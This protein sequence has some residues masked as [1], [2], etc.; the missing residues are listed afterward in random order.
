MSKNVSGNRSN[1][2]AMGI[3]S[4][5]DIMAQARLAFADRD[6]S[7]SLAGSAMQRLAYAIIAEQHTLAQ[8]SDRL[9]PLETLPESPEAM[10]TTRDKMISVFIAPLPEKPE[11]KQEKYEAAKTVF[12][13]QVQLLSRALTVAI[14]LATAK[15]KLDAFDAKTG[16]FSIP[17]KLLLAEGETAFGRL[18]SAKSIALDGGP[19]LVSGAEDNIMSLRASVT[20]L[21][22]VNAP[23][24]PRNTKKSASVGLDK[25]ASEV[26]RILTVDTAPVA[27]ADMSDSLKNSLA[28]IVKW[29]DE[30]QE[31]SRNTANKSAAK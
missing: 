30:Q 16:M 11:G 15:V 21:L 28:A 8:G 13:A 5:A 19:I 6:K 4:D 18:A 31:A 2:A 17:P 7:E 12:T 25:H 23:A 29:W 1:S 24:K 20:R 22:K 14:I 3:V 27:F 26:A 9:A 10:K